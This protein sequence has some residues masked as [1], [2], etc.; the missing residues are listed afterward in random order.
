MAKVIFGAWDNTVIDNRRK[1]CLR[2]KNI[3]NS[4]ILTNSIQEIPSKHFF[5]GHGFF[6]FE[7]NVNLLDAA[8]QYMERVAGNPAANAPLAG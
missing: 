1:R 4:A 7:K 2:L 6:I 5:G 8:L 3:L